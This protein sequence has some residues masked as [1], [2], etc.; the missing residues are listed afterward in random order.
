MFILDEK[1]KH[2]TGCPYK[3]LLELKCKQI[4]GKKQTLY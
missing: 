2:Q 1:F 4:I 3:P